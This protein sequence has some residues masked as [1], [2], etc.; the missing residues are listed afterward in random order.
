MNINKEWH[1][2]HKMPKNPTLDERIQWHSEHVKNC[3]CRPLHG[4]ILE[5]MKRRGLLLP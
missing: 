4:K 2:A 3:Q 5:E 1:L